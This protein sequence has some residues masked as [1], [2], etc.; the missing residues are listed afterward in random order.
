MWFGMDWDLVRLSNPHQAACATT[1][2]P[3]STGIPGASFGGYCQSA[4][5]DLFSP[6]RVEKGDL[7][8]LGGRDQVRVRS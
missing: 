8:S 3:S 4:P 2:P 5:L 7:L 1:A 6:L